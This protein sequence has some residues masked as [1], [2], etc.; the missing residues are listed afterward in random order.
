M[1]TL[2]VRPIDIQATAALRAAFVASKPDWEAVCDAVLAG[3]DANARLPARRRGVTALQ[4]A[5]LYGFT[6]AVNTLL[7]CGADPAAGSERH[8][9]A[10]NAAVRLG[11]TAI[12]KAL[13]EHGADPGAK[14]LDGRPPLMSAVRC[15]HTAIA[16]LLLDHGADPNATDAE[17]QTTLMHVPDTAWSRIE[18]SELIDLLV[19]RGADPLAR[20]ALGRTTLS[21]FA[22]P[23]R[24]D[25]LSSLDIALADPRQSAARH[26]VLARLNAAQRHRWLP[27]STAAAS[28]SV[29]RY[30]WNRHP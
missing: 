15:G 5:V 16:K 7:D 11:F 10:L 14:D 26:R 8:S 20:D 13:L 9:S 12:A 2:D 17:G 21:I 1:S 28:T 23:R 29:A 25:L 30:H 6:P 3:A 19:R 22:K 27:R 24:W 18:G 4:I